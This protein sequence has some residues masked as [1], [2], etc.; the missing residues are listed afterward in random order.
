[1][2]GT[3][4]PALSRPG[5]SF[6]TSLLRFWRRRR[7][8]PGSAGAAGKL[9][10]PLLA[11]GQQLRERREQRGLSL[12]QLA[13]ETRISTPVL[14]ALERG[15]RDRLPEA[16][17]LRSM[18]PL[19]EAELEMPPGCLAAALPAQRSPGSHQPQRRFTPGS[20]DVFTTWQ[21][22]VLY[23]VLTLGLIYALNLEQQRL[24]GE[25]R[26]ALR[27]IPPVPADEQQKP[28]SAAQSLLRVVPGLRPLDQA[29]SGQGLKLLSQGQR[30]EASGPGLL[31]LELQQSSR[32]TLSSNG[33]VST[34]LA[35]ASGQLRLPLTPP[36]RLRL[37]PAPGPG[38]RV[39]WNGLPLAA[40][41]GQP[42][43]FT[44]AE[45]PSP[46]PAAAASSP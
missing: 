30:S 7:P 35:A 13:L 36:F 6:S 27:P 14:E 5:A 15:W 21:G 8:E 29:A 25:G 18:L 26:L 45:T 10:D 44:V 28:E 40:V 24:A 17:Y 46:R 31:E 3:G 42:G 16:T 22:T 19:L 37:D 2:A 23:A 9:E 20:I 11:A 39:L 1:M 4:W 41:A 34:D 32:I 38:S 12:R 33:A 43:T